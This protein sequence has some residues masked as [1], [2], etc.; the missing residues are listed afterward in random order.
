M[1]VTTRW[2][3][4]VRAIANAAQ[5]FAIEIGTSGG[6]AIVIRSSA[7]GKSEAISLSDLRA[8]HEG[9]FPSLMGSELTPEF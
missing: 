8:A 9:F 6:D 5:L 7:T 3:E 2:P 1:L 4:G